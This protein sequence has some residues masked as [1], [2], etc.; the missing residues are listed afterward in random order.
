MQRSI[1]SSSLGASDEQADFPIVHTNA[2]TG[3]AVLPHKGDK[4]VGDGCDLQPL[5]DLILNYVPKPE[6]SI[7]MRPTQML[8]TSLGL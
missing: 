5:F 1:C 3:C 8:I 4:P 7:S 6:S 2:I